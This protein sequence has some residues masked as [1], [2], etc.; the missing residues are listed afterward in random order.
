MFGSLMMLP[1]ASRTTSP[2]LESSSGAKS[3]AARTLPA[4]EI[5]LSTTET[6]AA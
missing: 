4:R 6:P 5:S 2:S 1:S 3:I